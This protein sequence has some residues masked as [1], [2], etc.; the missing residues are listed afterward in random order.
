MVGN[1]CVISDSKIHKSLIFNDCRIDSG[2]ELDGVLVHPNCEIGAGS[3][4]R[5]V[6]L[7][8][9]CI[10][11]PGTVVGEN[12]EEDAKRFHLTEGRIV[13]INREMLGQERRYQPPD[14]THIPR[15]PD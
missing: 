6:L 14:Y 12:P 8:N 13:V 3:R 1:G 10:V 4:L 15:S 7:D 2:C 11:P 9:G 5:N